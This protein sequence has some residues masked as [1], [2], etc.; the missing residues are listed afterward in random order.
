[1]GKVSAKSSVADSIQLLTIISARSMLQ[2]DITWRSSWVIL[3]PTAPW[4]LVVLLSVELVEVLLLSDGDCAS[5]RTRPGAI[6]RVRNLG[7]RVKSAR[8]P[9]PGA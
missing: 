8:G 3:D 7:V 2:L 5:R 6:L 9:S 1:M 4:V